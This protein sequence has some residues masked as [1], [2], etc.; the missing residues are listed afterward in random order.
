MVAVL[1]LLEWYDGC[2]A[3]EAR[4]DV[5]NIVYDDK[6]KQPFLHADHRRRQNLYT[7]N[8]VFLITAMHSKEI[9]ITCCVQR[10]RVTCS[11]RGLAGTPLVDTNDPVRAFKTPCCKD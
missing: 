9:F 3:L 6:Q 10:R 5:V 11:T 4:R 7:K 1:V 2:L 8:Y